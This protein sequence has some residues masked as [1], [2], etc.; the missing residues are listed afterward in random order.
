V[1]PA[2]SELFEAGLELYRSRADKQWSMTDCISFVVMRREGITD[3]LTA[4]RR[5]EQAGFH[6]LLRP[7]S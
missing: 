5:F 7:G 2:S 4:D 3:A 1:I 6:V